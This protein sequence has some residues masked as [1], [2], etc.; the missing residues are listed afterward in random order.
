LSRAKALVLSQKMQT[1]GGAHSQSA[2]AGLLLFA[3]HLEVDLQ[4]HAGAG[5]GTGAGVGVGV[6]VD[7]VL[8]V[9]HAAVDAEVRRC[10]V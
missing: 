10:H 3:K 5:A 4:S 7:M 6:D 8:D 9:L 2:I 1:V